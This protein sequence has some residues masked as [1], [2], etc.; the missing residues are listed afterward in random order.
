MKKILGL[1]FIGC[2]IICFNGCETPQYD[3]YRATEKLRE[4]K[5]QPIKVAEGVYFKRVNI[6]G[7]AALLQCDKDGNIIHNQ[8]INAADVSG[9][10]IKNSSILTVQ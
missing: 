10:N 4:Y 8:N 6:Q 5:G 2:L 1:L 9:K 7:I 3:D